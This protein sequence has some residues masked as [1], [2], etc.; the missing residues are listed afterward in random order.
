MFKLTGNQTKEFSKIYE[1]TKLMRSTTDIFYNNIKMLHYLK[2]SYVTK[3]I[4]DDLYDGLL[5]DI[6][7]V[8]SPID[9]I[10]PNTNEYPLDENGNQIIPEDYQICVLNDVVPEYERI[11]K[12]VTVDDIKNNTDPSHPLH[13]AVVE[14]PENISKILN[15]VYKW[16]LIRRYF[17]QI[18]ML[19]VN[20]ISIM[21]PIIEYIVENI[22]LD[23]IKSHLVSKNINMEKVV[24]RIK[25]SIFL[26][27]LGRITTF[28]HTENPI[29]DIFDAEDLIKRLM[30]NLTLKSDIYIISG[31]YHLLTFALNDFSKNIDSFNEQKNEGVEVPD[32]SLSKCEEYVMDVLSKI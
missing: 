15:D 29:F 16:W 8:S 17:V 31:I 9:A 1:Q 10:I 14:N 30:T 7:L 27:D 6:E 19:H 25:E 23:D 11:S 26:P 3:E 4:Y 12:R 22:T 20:Q 13:I 28:Y 21:T 24:P 2:T 18:E 5:A 32:I